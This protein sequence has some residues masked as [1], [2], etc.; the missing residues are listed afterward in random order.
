MP[1]KIEVLELIR[2]MTL[3]RIFNILK[4]TITFYFSRLMKKVFHKGMPLAISFEPTNCCNLRCPECLSGAGELQRSEGNAS[5]EF[6]SSLIDQI[7][8]ETFYLNMYF[9]GEPFLNPYFFRMIEY[10]SQKNIFVSSSTNGHYLSENN[11]HSLINS[12]LKKITVSLDGSTQDVYE[13]YRVGGKMEKVLSGLK[14]LVQKRKELKRRFPVIVIQFLVFKYNEHQINE[15]RVL[16][17]EIGVDRLELKS[18]QIYHDEKMGELMPANPAYSRYK[19]NKD[20]SYSLKNRPFNHC[21]RSWHSC[22]LTWDGLLLPCCFDKKG[23]YAFASLKDNKFEK[24]WKSNEFN[25]FRYQL[26]KSRLE[27]DICK[28]CTEGKNFFI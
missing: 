6:F 7:H 4:I 17:K 9:Q 22:V 11:C 10:A 14:L 13:K 20:G 25:H 8:R 16:S 23:E 12:G 21:W 3:R 24:I 18:A 5:Y 19:E 15:I 26:L 27:I 1:L 2:I 28:N